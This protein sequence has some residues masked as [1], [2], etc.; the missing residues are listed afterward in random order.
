MSAIERFHCILKNIVNYQIFV[1]TSISD[2]KDNKQ[3]R[4]A[5]FNCVIIFFH[6]IFKLQRGIPVNC[7]VALSSLVTL[8]SISWILTSSM[9]I[10]LWAS[11]LIPSLFAN[12]GSDSSNS[13][14]TKFFLDKHRRLR[15]TVTARSKPIRRFKNNTGNKSTKESLGNTFG[16]C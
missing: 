6:N 2:W 3:N 12:S 11:L 13:L 8:K 5:I 10:E 15:K 1:S 7:I 4:H 9:S 14:E 16:Y